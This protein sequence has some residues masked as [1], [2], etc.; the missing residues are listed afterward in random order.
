[1]HR[2]CNT[3]ILHFD[4]K[5]HNILLGENFCPKISDF[6]L[7]KFCS[8]TEKSNISMSEAR[9]TIGY[10]APEVFCRN[11]GDVS[12]KSDVY[13]DGMMVLEVIGC[14]KNANAKVDT[15][16]SEYFPYWIY[17][18]LNRDEELEGD[19]IMNTEDKCLQR[20][21]ILVSLWCI[22]TIPFTRPS[23]DRVVQMLEGSPELIEVPPIPTF[24]S[25]PRAPSDP[26]GSSTITI[27][28]Y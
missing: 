6:G 16:S 10:I 27:N 26:S 25:P 17:K 4:I 8:Q 7:A 9:G 28:S 5:P 2:G 22:Q 15:S 14:R 3:R 23:M 21:M 20:K 11:F 13:S 24:S 12:Y 19:E 18:Q 1:M